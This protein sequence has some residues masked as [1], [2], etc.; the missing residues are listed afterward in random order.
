MVEL[1]QQQLRSGINRTQQVRVAEQI[2][3]QNE[4]QA[5]V[6]EQNRIITQQNAQ[7]E[8]DNL[9]RELAV[10]YANRKLRGKAGYMP[11]YEK[12]PEMRELIGK[13]YAEITSTSEY[14]RNRQQAVEQYGTAIEKYKEAGFKSPQEYVSVKQEQF[15]K[16]FSTTGELYKEKIQSQ[17]SAGE[18]A[19]LAPPSFLAGSVDEYHPLDCIVQVAPLSVET[20]NSH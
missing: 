8:K 20:K 3:Q 13:Y 1:T 12:D 17:L 2:R 11:Q 6:D 14:K 9:A 4:E 10:K 19:N 5:R 16:F 7:I 18:T 15:G